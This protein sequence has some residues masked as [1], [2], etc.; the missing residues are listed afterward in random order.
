LNVKENI[1]LSDLQ[2]GFN[3]LSTL[4]LSSNNVLSNLSCI[5]NQLSVLDVSSNILLTNVDCSGNLFTSLDFSSNTALFSLGCGSNQ[6]TTL[7]L[8]ANAALTYLLCFDNNL[9]SLNLSSNIKL[10]YL[11]C[12]SNQLTSLN[13][14]NNTLLTSI[15]CSGNQLISLDV[16][17][18]TSLTILDC[19]NNQLVSLNVQNGNNSNMT[20]DWNKVLK[21]TNNSNL[22]CIK[23][24]DA[25]AAEIYTDWQKDATATYSEDC[26]SLEIPTEL[27]VSS[28]TLTPE[29]IGCFNATQI[30]TVAGDGTQVIVESGASANFIAG[31]NIRFLPGFRSLAG[32][33]THAYITTT[34]DYCLEAT[35]AIV[36]AENVREKEAIIVNTEITELAQQEMIVYPNPNNGEFTVQFQNFEG[37]TRVMLFN[38]IGQLIEDKLTTE[39]EIRMYVPNV[40]SGMYFIK[41]VNKGEQFSRKIVVR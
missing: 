26:S 36:A 37:E 13:L 25:A 21:V 39:A 40:K 1:V 5:Y 6:L 32:S 4:E 35:P 18:N 11:D 10:E 41:A 24:D 22:T 30:I 19:R 8:T 27:A 28:T 12:S 31:Q 23:V 3:Q 34:N 14:N 15:Y 7:D 29:E 2:C 16:S 20:G 17:A 9:T 33:N 38:S